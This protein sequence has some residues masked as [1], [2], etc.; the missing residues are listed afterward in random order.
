MQTIILKYL[1]PITAG[2]FFSGTVWGQTLKITRISDN[3]YVYTTYKPF[4]NTLISANGLYLVTENGV[5]LFDTPWDET[6]FQPLLD[7]I[8]SK[9]G[10]KV[11]MCISTHSHDDRAAGLGY[12]REQGIPTYTTSQTDSILKKLGEP[13]AEHILYSDTTFH[14]GNYTFETHFPGHGHTGDNIVIWIEELRLLYGGC[15]VKSVEA[16]DLGYVADA[17]LPSWEMAIRKTMK[18]YNHP[19]FIITGHQDWTDKR[20]LKHTLKL[21]KKA[22]RKPTP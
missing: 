6:Q 12:Y 18:R 5:I 9:H 7:S 22:N 1:I 4:K 19:D 3:C 16:I 2:L 10:K 8:Q 17:N 15:F 21:L 13:R 20:S 11:L 14:I